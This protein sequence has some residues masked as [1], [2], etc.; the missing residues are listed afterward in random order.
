MTEDRNI[1][2]AQ[3]KS[4]APRYR[5]MD[6]PLLVTSRTLGVPVEYEL[7]SANISISGILIENER[8][9]RIPFNVNT[10]LEMT[11]DPGSQWLQRPVH[12]I[13]K[14]IRVAHADS[15][16]IQFGVKIVQIDGSESNVWEICFLH[17]EEHAKHLLMT[18]KPSDA[19]TAPTLTLPPAA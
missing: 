19:V 15:G 13:G 6:Q 10:L 9:L 14:V 11:I 2:G 8:N 3:A 16:A 5:T 12:C 7:V 17:L 1:H 18:P 4:A